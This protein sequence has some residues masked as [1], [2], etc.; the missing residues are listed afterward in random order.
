MAAGQVA[1]A[2]ERA[3][4][5]CPERQP[6]FVGQALVPLRAAEPRFDLQSGHGL[7]RLAEG[8]LTSEL[9][10]LGLG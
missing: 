1:A 7:S 6:A 10:D 9:A 3:V 4:A 8:T 5:Q 2:V